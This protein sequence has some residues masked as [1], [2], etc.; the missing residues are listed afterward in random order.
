[1]VVDVGQAGQH[2]ARRVR[3]GPRDR[4]GVGDHAVR[5][6]QVPLVVVFD[7]ACANA[8]VFH[9]PVSTAVACDPACDLS[10]YA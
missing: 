8:K 3:L 10:A 1:M 9:E 2:P 7:H 5:D 6:D 4:I